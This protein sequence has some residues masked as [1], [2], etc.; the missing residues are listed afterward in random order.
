MFIYIAGVETKTSISVWYELGRKR[1]IT[2]MNVGYFTSIKHTRQINNQQ[3]KGSQHTE[4][5]PILK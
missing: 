4:P 3:K 1:H 2:A 5:A